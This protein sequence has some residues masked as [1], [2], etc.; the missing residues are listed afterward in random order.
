MYIMSEQFATWDNNDQQ[1]IKVEVEVDETPPEVDKIDVKAENKIEIKFT[2]ELDEDSAEDEDNYTLLDKD[3]KEVKDI[4]DDVDYSSKKVTILFEEDLSGDYTIVL[5]NIKDKAGNK[6]S[7]TAVDFNVGDK[8]APNKDDFK[9][10]LYRAGAEDQM[11]R[12]DF[13]DKMATDGKYAV[14]DVEKYVIVDGSTRINL[15]KIEDVEI[16]VVDDGEAVEIYVPS[17]KDIEKDVKK[18]ESGKHYYDFTL[19]EDTN[20]KVIGVNQKIEIA[21]VADAAGN[22]VDFMTHQIT[23]NV[24]ESIKITKAEATARDTIEITFDDELVD[25]E[26]DDIIIKINGE[27]KDAKDDIAGVTTKLN[28]DG[29]TVAV[30]T[31]DS[32]M[33]PASFEE[34]DVVVEVVGKPESENRYER[35]LSWD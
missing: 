21:R 15:E 5:Q 23:L 17:Y 35:S 2:E 13:N 14:T 34:G 7:K 24:S 18:P 11:I 8:T 4:F 1:M 6:M 30:F 16:V 19:M 29:N 12:I 25:F 10:T 9:A 26:A 3:G 32:D 27:A 31:L 28:K 20:G 33:I 22:K